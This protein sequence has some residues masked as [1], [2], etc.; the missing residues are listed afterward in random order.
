MVT[1]QHTFTLYAANGRV[2]A[3]NVAGKVVDLG[4]LRRDGESYAYLLDADEIRAEGFDTPEAALRDIGKNITFLY[5]DGQFTA[6]PDVRSEVVLDAAASVKV[7]PRNDAKSDTER[8]PP[9]GL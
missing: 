8:V 3:Q 6:L 7:E 4:E 9:T 1:R 5:L 2:Y